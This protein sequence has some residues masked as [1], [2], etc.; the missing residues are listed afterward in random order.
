WDPA[1]SDSVQFFLDSADVASWSNASDPANGARVELLTDDVRLRVIG[2]ALRLNARSSIA[3]DTV[4]VLTATAREVTFVYDPL[5]P[6]PTDGMRI[7]GAPAWRTVLD[8]AVPEALTG[9]PELCAAVGCPFALAPRHVSYA[10]LALRTRTVEA[11]YQPT[12]SI[13]LDV[14]PV[15]NKGSLPKSPL[16]N[17]L[18]ADPLG[19]RVAPIL[20]GAQERSLVEVPVTGY[21]RAFLAGADQ[22]GR[23]PP[24]TLAILSA[25]EPARF[26]FGS[27]YGPEAPEDQLEPVLKLV[28][29]VSP[30]M[31]LQ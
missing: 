13:S 21:V 20:F 2:G 14:R 31:E 26:A 15:L 1:V 23:P 3:P 28:L 7:G 12:D 22:S 10:A 29:T 18:I 11:P 19:L 4:L 5:A 27:F 17:S 8:V 6:P 30:P 24:S 16:G 25:R 9:P